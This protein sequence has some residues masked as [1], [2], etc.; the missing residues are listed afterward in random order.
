MLD[1]LGNF[2][3]ADFA[4]GFL[5]AL[6]VAATVIT[7]G[8]PYIQGNVFA[9]RMK[10]VSDER[11]E[12][13]KRERARLASEGERGSLRDK[14]KASSLADWT[15]ELLN[16][17]KNLADDGL[18]W[19]LKM[20]GWRK[21][22][23]MTT[24]LFFRIVMPIVF[25]LL[26]IFYL[27]VVQVVPM[28]TPI[29]IITVFAVAYIGFYA[30]NIIL[31]NAIQKRQQS[32][33]RAWPDALDLLLICVESG[34]SIEHAFRRVTQEIGLQSVPLAEE[35]ALTT[36]ELAYL[37]DRRQAYENL[38]RRTGLE[39]VRAVMT[40]LIQAERYGTP[41]GTALRVMAQ[42]NRDIRMAEVEKKAA[43]LPPKLTVPMI[44]FF[45]PVLFVVILGPAVIQVLDT[46]G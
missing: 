42:E 32:V 9:T 14:K 16:L 20:A 6:A 38:G 8:M 34:Q 19:K 31:T 21:P 13:R 37:E 25:F 44:L 26:G 46:L 18:A 10:Y 12:L 2:L 3:Q 40:S 7:I 27:F 45:L 17:R 41:L 5:A 11:E 15:V 1:L 33:K 30:P 29:K 43:A 28:P 23:S 24:F 35:M 4:I 36:A 22:S 39:G